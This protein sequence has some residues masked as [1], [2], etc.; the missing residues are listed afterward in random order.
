MELQTKEVLEIRSEEVQEII[1]QVPGWLLRWGISLIFILLIA[2]LATSWFIRYPDVIKA[3][4]VVTTNPAPITV[5]SR[6]SGKI[7]LLKKP[8]ELVKKDEIIAT[9]Q[10]NVGYEDVLK[11]E[12]IIRQP[13]TEQSLSESLQVG[14]LQSFM[15]SNTFA[16]QEWKAFQKN[17]LHQKTN[18]PFVKTDY[19]L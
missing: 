10:T 1:S 7:L 2:L 17:E 8:N 12:R 5:V 15:N 19:F 9:L 13:P 16:L 14:E 3:T 11:L 18:G 4:L 6:A